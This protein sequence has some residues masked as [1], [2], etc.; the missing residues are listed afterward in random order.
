VRNYLG[1]AM[2]PKAGLTIGL[3]MLVQDRFP[4]LATTIAAIELAAVAV[5]ELIGPLG[6]KFALQASKEMNVSR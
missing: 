1:F 5:C 6:T 2:L 4:E 3:L